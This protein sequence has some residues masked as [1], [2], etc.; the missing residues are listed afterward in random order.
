ML[1]KLDDTEALQRVMTECHIPEYMQGGLVRWLQNGIEPGS[2]M[3]AVLENNL[4]EACNRADDTNR[5]HLYD[6]V[7]FL[8]NYAPIGAWGSPDNVRRWADMNLERRSKAHA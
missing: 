4:S 6:Y 8:H 5:H 7:Y 3:L 2:F 1:V